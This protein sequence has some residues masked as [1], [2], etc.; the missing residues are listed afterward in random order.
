MEFKDITQ[1]VERA[2]LDGTEKIVISK[3]NYLLVQK[4][5]DTMDSKDIFAGSQVLNA[6]KAYADSKVYSYDT[7][8]LYLTP[9]GVLTVTQPTGAGSLLNKTLNTTESLLWTQNYTI[10]SAGTVLSENLYYI[11][12]SFNNLPNNK[13]VYLRLNYTIG[14]TVIFNLSELVLSLDTTYDLFRMIINEQVADLDYPANTVASLKIYGR[15]QSGTANISILV[16]DNIRNSV[17]V[18]NVPVGGYSAT[19]IITNAGGIKRT[20]EE[21]NNYI[22]TLL[23]P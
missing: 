12:L 6:A 14:S 7:T 18:R 23:N 15:S 20:Q 10:P 5:F 4:L 9:S 16:N 3:D 19:N 1:L 21:F 11:W 17:L 8:N 22:L 13:N 2:I